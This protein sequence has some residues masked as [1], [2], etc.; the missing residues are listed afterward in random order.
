MIYSKENAPVGNARKIKEKEKSEAAR[1]KPAP[2]EYGDL[3]KEQDS[4][5]WASKNCLENENGRAIRAAHEALD[6]GNMKAVKELVGKSKRLTAILEKRQE[7][8]EKTYKKWKVRQGGGGNRTK[9]EPTGKRT[10]KGFVLGISYEDCP[11]DGRRDGG[12]E[13]V[14][15]L[16]SIQEERNSHRI[17]IQER[18]TDQCMQRKKAHGNWY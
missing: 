9:F 2:K 6:T 16:G 17:C 1:H 13:E 4:L 10:G 15:N 14:G 5:P 12:K 18:S 8:G 11:H 3:E 7:G